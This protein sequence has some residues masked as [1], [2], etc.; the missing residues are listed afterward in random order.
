MTNMQVKVIIPCFNGENYLEQCLDS[1]KNQI[2]PFNDV[3]LINDAS[4]DNSLNLAVRS[5]VCR[6]KSNETNKGIGAVRKEG[7][8]EQSGL[9]SEDYVVFLSHDDAFHPRYLETMLKYADGKSILL[10]DYWQCNEKLEPQKVFHAPTFQTQEELKKLVLE[11]ALQHN[12]FIN[13]SGVM[14]PKY[15]FKQVKFT[16]LRY[17]EDLAFTLNALLQ[18]IPFKHVPEPLVFYRLHAKS[19]SSRGMSKKMWR[20]FWFETAPLLEGLGTQR[21]TIS[22]AMR[23]HYDSLFSFRTQVRRHTPKLIKRLY[24]SVFH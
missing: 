16:N 14:I 24:K 23:N 9:V 15:V 4:T 1:V 22:N 19:G 21:E 8:E 13:F 3:L 7:S 2:N 20:A 5:Q 6:I 12:L 11:W 17:G 10:C 18:K